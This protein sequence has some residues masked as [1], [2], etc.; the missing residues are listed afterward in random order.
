[1]TDDQREKCHFIIHGASV[2]AAA[3]GAGLAQLP[4]SDSALIIPAQIAMVVGLGQV[5]DQ[6]ITESAAK[7]FVFASIGG[8]VGRAAS[9]ILLGWIPFLG[10][11]INASTAAG[12]TEALGWV[13]VDKLD[14][15]EIKG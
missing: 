14:K 1:M 9:Q 11:A 13:V 12:I 5:F 7:G 3:V 4:M 8:L 15:G 6:H 10:N 2:A